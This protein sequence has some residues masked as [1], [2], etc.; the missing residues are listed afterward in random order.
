MAWSSAGLWRSLLEVD[1]LV[2]RGARAESRKRALLWS[3]IWI[4]T[5]LAFTGYLA[6]DG[7]SRAEEYRAAYLVEKS[8]S[9][10]SA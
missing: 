10:N 3:A 6:A 2:H 9:L 5:G 4:A 1:P 7:K 8:L